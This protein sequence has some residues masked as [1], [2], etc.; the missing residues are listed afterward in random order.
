VAAQQLGGT[1]SA[2]SGGTGQGARFSVTIPIN[3][4]AQVDRVAAA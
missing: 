4:A 3:S 1:I 2:E